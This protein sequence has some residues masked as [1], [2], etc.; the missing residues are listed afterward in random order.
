MGAGST[1]GVVGVG[2]GEG[3]GDGSTST[4]WLSDGLG[5]GVATTVGVSIGTRTVTGL[6]LI[7]DVFENE[8][9]VRVTSL[10][11]RI[12]NDQLIAVGAIDCR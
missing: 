5:L 11:A 7:I 10:S 8:E 6:I 2:T 3:L 9:Y 4:V 1:G 12:A